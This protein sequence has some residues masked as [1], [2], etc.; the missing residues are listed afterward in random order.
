MMSSIQ[1]QIPNDARYILKS[2]GVTGPKMGRNH[3]ETDQ[4]S[5]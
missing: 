1:I 4:S 3:A 2:L 5:F